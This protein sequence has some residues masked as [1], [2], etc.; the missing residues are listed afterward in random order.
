MASLGDRIKEYEKVTRTFA[1]KRTPLIIRV[2]GRAF[3]TFTKDMNRPFDTKLMSAMVLAATDVANDMQGFKVAY[4]QSDEVTFCITDYDN[5][6]SQGWFNYNLSKIISISSAMMSVNLFKHLGYI[7][8]PVF[9]SRAFNV[10]IDDV[11]NVFVWRAQDWNRNS[12]QMYAHDNFTH[13]ELHGKNKQDMHNM[14]HGIGKNWTTDLTDQE[15]NGAFI[16]NTKQGFL[17][18]YDVEPTYE[19]IN[20]L[21]SGI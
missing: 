4:I 8:T 20:N 3:H 2:D 6:E 11:V 18:K 10:P 19:S 14:L 1:T 12:L 9:D 15:K 7:K 17:Y 16:V 13:K 5:L 21:F